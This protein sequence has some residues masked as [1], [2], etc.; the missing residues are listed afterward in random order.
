MPID[1]ACPD[2]DRLRVAV[3]ELGH[4]V[5]W[6]IAAN[7]TPTAIRVF[8]HGITAHG[9]VHV[10]AAVHTVDDA[11]GYL[12]G[13]LAGREAALRWCE[14]NGLAHPEWTCSSDV[15]SFRQQR[16][17]YELCRQVS[18]ADARATARRIVRTH[19]ALIV[20][21]APRLARA[22]RITV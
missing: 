14:E 8:G 19:W 10:D 17:D 9:Y 7:T 15:S 4:A 2:P 22:G 5:A 3:H 21:L 6:K 20:R 13:L 1:D 11:R 16:R 12:A 18:T